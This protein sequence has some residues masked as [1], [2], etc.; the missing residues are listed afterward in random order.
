ME[1]IMSTHSD[2]LKKIMALIANDTPQPQL[3]LEVNSL[4]TEITRSIK[5]SQRILILL[6]GIP[7]K[8]NI[9]PPVSV[10]EIKTNP[11]SNFVVTNEYKDSIFNVAVNSARDGTIDT[12]SIITEMRRLGD[13]RPEKQMLIGIGNI[14]FQR[15][16]KKIANCKY[17]KP[18][19]LPN[20]EVK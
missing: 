4:K 3:T 6:E 12:K 16:W 9:P 2:G 10:T 19:T 17:A 13:T 8:L 1:D 15:G 14:L 11:K 18:E 20:M 7:E 5:E